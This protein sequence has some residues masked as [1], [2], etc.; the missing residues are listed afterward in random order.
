MNVMRGHVRALVVAVTAVAFAGAAGTAQNAAAALPPGNAVE[1]WNKIAE[2]TVVGSGAFQNEGL[3][4]MAYE[5]AAVYDAVVAI[6][7]D[8]APYGAPIAAAAGASADAAVVEAAY[9]TLVNYFPTQAT[10]LGGQYAEALTLIPD[11][12]A[13]DDGKAVGL[14]AANQIINLRNGDGR[15]TPIGVSTS[16]STLVQA[17]GVWRLT[18]PFALPQTPW[19]ANVQPFILSSADQVLP[20][21]PPSLQSGDWVKGFNEIKKYG[22][23]NSSIRTTA[24]TNVARFWSANVI[25]QYNGLARDVADTRGL[26]LVRTARLTAM[27]NVVGADAQI[28]V[29]HAKYHYLFWRPVTAING[30][31]DATAVTSDGFGPVP[32][33][34]DGNAATAEQAG[35]RPLLPTPNHPEYPAAHGSLTSAMSEVFTSFLGTS[36]IDVSIHGFDPS[37]ATGNLNA[38]RHFDKANDLRREIIDARVWAGVHYRFSGVAGVV[39]GRKVA[40]YDLRRAFQPVG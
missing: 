6:E 7:G 40:K 28:S 19:V 23:A 11:G 22:A 21:P 32:G 18:P 38:I 25:R 13:K 3:I 8:Y 24:Q 1:Q 31:L 30:G 2:N 33:Y 36:R 4:Y 37:G 26:D 29:M 34:G 10:T 16:F 20:D 12:A 15:T 35:W 5:S 27:V 39:L 9:R 14:A 17:P